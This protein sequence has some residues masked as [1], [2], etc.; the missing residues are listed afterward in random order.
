MVGAAATVAAGAGAGGVASSA[1]LGG[2]P[3]YNWQFMTQPAVPAGQSTPGTPA[4]YMTGSGQT[5]ADAYQAMLA[6][7]G[8]VKLANGT[9]YA[10]AWDLPQQG[11]AIG[12]QISAA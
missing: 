1:G 10:S 2:Q 3:I 11:G 5:A 4:T 9:T 8:P 12:A 6:A 7:Q